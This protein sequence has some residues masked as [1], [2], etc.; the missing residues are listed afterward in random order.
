MTCLAP[1]DIARSETAVAL[2]ATPELNRELRQIDQLIGALRMVPLR[3]SED[4]DDLRWL[5]ERRAFLLSVLA[6]RFKQKRQ[7][8]VSLT[9]WRSGGLP[10][11]EIP[12][13]VA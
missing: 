12:S 8:I 4:F 10:V 6:W 2:A 11:A 13:R 9:L 5:Q 7:K 3:G 1:A